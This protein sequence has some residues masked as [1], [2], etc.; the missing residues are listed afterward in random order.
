M[1]PSL[2]LWFHPSVYGSI[3]LSMVPSL[4]L[5]FQAISWC[6]AAHEPPLWIHVKECLN[7]ILTSSILQNY[8]IHRNWWGQRCVSSCSSGIIFSQHILFPSPPNTCGKLENS[9]IEFP[10][11][12]IS[13]IKLYMK[14]VYSRRKSPGILF[15][16]KRN[17]CWSLAIHAC[18]ETQPNVSHG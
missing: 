8:F 15:L 12:E 13:N 2:C 17:L 16:C 11:R 18:N 3:P 7:K 10:P 6:H 5:W 1:V 4:C 9:S 14:D